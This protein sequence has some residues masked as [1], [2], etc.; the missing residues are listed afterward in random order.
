MIFWSIA[1]VMSHNFFLLFGLT[2]TDTPTLDNKGF[3]KA[4][5]H[6][7]HPAVERFIDP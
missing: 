6:A 7:C 3:L 2:N 5:M 1:S 4:T